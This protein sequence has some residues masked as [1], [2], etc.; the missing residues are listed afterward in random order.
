[1][2][3]IALA[4]DNT[5]GTFYFYLLKTPVLN[6]NRTIQCYRTELN[7]TYENRVPMKKFFT[8]VPCAVIIFLLVTA[9]T[10]A[11]SG[12]AFRDYNNNGVKDTYEPGVAGILVKSYTVGD[13]LYGTATTASN[14][15]YTLSPAVG[16]GQPLRIEFE[17]PSSSSNFYGAVNTIDHAAP[18][19]GVYGTAVQFV[20]GP[21][22]S[23]NFAINN[24]AEYVSPNNKLATTGYVGGD[25]LG[26]GNAGTFDALVSFSYSN[27]GPTGVKQTLAQSLQTGSTWGLSYSKKRKKLFASAFLK[28]H[29]GLG[30]LGLDGIYSIDI[31]GGAPV[32]SKFIELADDY[33]YSVGTIPSNPLRGLSIARE[34]PSVDAAAFWEIGKIGL[35]AIELS[36]DERYLYVT[37]LYD[38]KLYKITVDADNNP[39]TPP[40]AAD[41]V[42]YSIPD[43]GCTG[44]NYRPFAIKYY[45]GNVYVGVICDA[46]T[47]QN[48]NNLSATVF[49]FDGIGFTTVLTAP[50]NYSKGYATNGCG[51]LRQWNP[52]VNTV[53]NSCIESQFVHEQ[54]ILSDIEFDADGTMILGF[55]DRFGHQMGFNNFMPD[56]PLNTTLADTRAGGDILRAYNHNGIF[57]LE[58]NAKEGVN[59]A[60]P[61]TAG[62]GSNDGPGGG[63]FYYRDNFIDNI[64]GSVGHG[65]ITNGGLALIPGFNEVVATAYDPIDHRDY[66][67]HGGLIKLNNTSGAK[68]SAFIIF[69]QIDGGFGKSINL[70]DIE[71]LG[72]LAPIEIG[73]RVWDDLNNNNIQDAG[74]PGFAGVIVELYDASGATLLASVTTDANGN[75][76]FNNTNVPAG[77]LPNTNYK[78][79]VSK[80][81]YNTSGIGI[82]TGYTLSIANQVGNGLVGYSDSDALLM[83][84]GSAEINVTTADYGWSNHHLDIGFVSSA[85]LAKED[86]LL[87]ATKKNQSVILEWKAEINNDF[88][89]FVI[90]HSADGRFFSPLYTTA[91]I[92]NKLSYVYTHGSP[93]MRA[94]Y[95]RV[96]AVN[97]NNKNRYTPVQTIVLENRT[98]MKVYPNPVKN[99]VMVYL[100][101]PFVNHPIQLDIINTAGQV[102][103]SKSVYSA[104]AQQKIDVRVLNKGLYYIRAKSANGQ[105]QIHKILVEK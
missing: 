46:F 64:N 8:I 47:S 34:N 63:E 93:L 3:E 6:S 94:N 74:E 65:E 58:Q 104:T 21:V 37:N 1:M 75:W 70:G 88:V 44:G 22:A 60:K 19:G 32:V 62:A 26:G 66:W 97:A 39:A 14:G 78:V 23:V 71:W 40:A 38:R 73:N 96:K 98:T 82:L 79:R 9:S 87:T 10:L 69:P 50:L 55:T 89:S 36:D 42:S 90:E 51:F 57:E 84:D 101:D 85:L 13:V 28:R 54:P 103:L 12:T 81:Q 102:V 20:T 45:R 16:A 35:G 83:G 61:A 95:Y 59:S 30:P 4:I 105:I 11:Q 86:I 68:N 24:P 99:D 72:E 31:S 25:P 52:W 76:Y 77:I 5:A 49:R 18:N 7:P 80:T 29:T 15:T 2:G 27:S 92:K 33:G 43:P 91:T 56:Y 48:I 100:P 41:I 53:P 17:I 67:F